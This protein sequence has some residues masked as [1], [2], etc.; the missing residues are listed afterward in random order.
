MLCTFCKASTLKEIKA[1]YKRNIKGQR[2]LIKNVPAVTCDECGDIYFDNNIIT[3]IRA[4]IFDR[5]TKV[6]DDIKV[7]NYDDIVD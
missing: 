3:K 7:Y 5:D 6:T 4:N 1:D 2:Y